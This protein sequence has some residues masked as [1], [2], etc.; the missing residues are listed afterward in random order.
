MIQTPSQAKT[1]ESKY[2]V[3][4][5]RLKAAREALGIDH[6]EVAAQLFLHATII[7]MLESGQF[8]AGLPLLFV[9]G[10]IRSY[11]KFLEIPDAEV[12]AAL[13]LLNPDALSDEAK[14]E[15]TQQTKPVKKSEK[16]NNRINK[17]TISMS[18]AILIIGCT[19]SFWWLAPDLFRPLTQTTE[20]I[21]K[22]TRTKL[23]IISKPQKATKLNTYKN[24]I[25]I[26][27]Q[28]IVECVSTLIAFILV[29][30]FGMRKASKA[31]PKARVNQQNNSRPA[32]ILSS[33]RSPG[34]TQQFFMMLKNHQS[35]AFFSFIIVS[36]IVGV[37]INWQHQEMKPTPSKLPMVVSK[38]E[39]PVAQAPT[40]AAPIILNLDDLPD[41][42]ESADFNAVL[43]TQF[44]INALQA[45]VNQL[46]QYQ[47]TANDIAVS[48]TDP[49][50]PL[51]EL[52]TKYPKYKKSYRRNVPA[53]LNYTSTVNSRT[54]ATPV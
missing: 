32:L 24:E 15:I 8:K 27:N 51:G 1:I 40:E 54:S 48:L 49:V 28:P 4:G 45:L 18:A 16:H 21:T 23:A 33:T 50:T 38:T 6:K 7:Q 47:Q 29:F 31:S 39:A 5:T 42:L 26:F 34:I 14:S 35:F 44:K 53:Y 3:F 12:K 19:L 22:Q 20:V 2:H 36:S 13:D 37:T 30:L 43:Q 25:L 17:T 10:Y 9:R 41:A 46:D 52:G 11:S